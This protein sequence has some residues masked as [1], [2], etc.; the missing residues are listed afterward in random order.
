[1]KG[2][3]METR[4]NTLEGFTGFFNNEQACQ[5]FFEA[6]RFRDGEYCPFCGHR[7]I[8]RFKDGRFRCGGCKKDFSIKTKTIFGE[9]KIP[10]RKWFLAIY[11]LTSAK[12]GVSSV[13]LAKQVG[14]TQKT[15]W[16][17]DHRIRKAMKQNPGQ[18]FGIIEAD[19]TYVGGKQKNKHRNKQVGCSGG[20]NTEVKTPVFGALQR[21]GGIRA[22]AVPDSRMRTLE[23]QI[24]KHVKFGST[25]HTDEWVGYD[26]VGRYFSHA[27]IN[28]SRG[29]YVRNGFVHTNGIESF[30]A[31]FKR[32]YVGIYHW[33]SPKHMQRYV[34]E[35]SYRFNARHEKDFAQVFSSVVGG[36][37][38]GSNLPYKTLTADVA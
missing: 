9:S 23:S 8:Y 22:E 21:G 3:T 7:T 2:A 31:L 11:L 33:M 37:A 16:F 28:H 1:M 27:R 38:T 5:T 30:W 29:Q 17:M 35:F 19:E 36:V 6:V 32:G 34:D 26:R 25:V 15:A 14:V 24:V 20:R 18:L 4:F 10:L 12:K 13:Q